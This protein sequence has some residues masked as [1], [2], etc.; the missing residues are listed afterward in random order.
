MDFTI[1]FAEFWRRYLDAHRKPG[2]RA[3][4]YAATVLGIASTV[5]AIHQSEPMYMI[6]GIAL[7]YAIAIGSHW[8][9]E[10]NQPLIR[11]NALYGAVADLK[12]CWLALTRRA[13]S[14]KPS[15]RCSKK[16]WRHLPTVCRSKP[17]RAATA[18]F[19]PPVAPARTIRARS[20]SAC[21]VLRR[22]TSPVSS[23]R[24]AS[25]RTNGFKIGPPIVTSSL[26]IQGSV[27]H[28]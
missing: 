14:H 16:R 18:L 3:A 5:A 6:G 15:T 22:D 17:S 20:A 11:V 27:H 9:I 12:M 25:V 1:P 24:S 23:A 8:M 10:G 7:S 4:H 19:W 21:A 13:S 26:Q 28:N 2:T